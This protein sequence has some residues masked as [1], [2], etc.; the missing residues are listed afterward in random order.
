MLMQF[1]QRHEIDV[2]SKMQADIKTFFISYLTCKQL[3]RK[4]IIFTD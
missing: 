1:S 3:F 2:I 4:E